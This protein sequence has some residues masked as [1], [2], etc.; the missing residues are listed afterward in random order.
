[1]S[2]NK[3]IY[4]KDNDLM[5]DYFFKIKGKKIVRYSAYKRCLW[6]TH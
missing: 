6:Y 5:L 1:M 4:D 3:T 2:Y